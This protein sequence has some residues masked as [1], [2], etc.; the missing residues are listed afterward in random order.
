[1]KIKNTKFFL[2]GV[3]CA[4]FLARNIQDGQFVM[5]FFFAVVAWQCVRAS[6]CAK[7]L[8]DVDAA[9]LAAL[10]G[11]AE[12]E[13]YGKL[14]GF[15]WL[16]PYGALALCAVTGMLVPGVRMPVVYLFLLVL[17]AE[18]AA[19]IKVW[20]KMKTLLESGGM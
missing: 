4:L 3:L 19:G 11:Q 7:G 15:A 12:R 16:L 14:A 20:K 6:L 17:C 13:V 5:C 18:L 10:R 8:E 1:M 2:C 9:A